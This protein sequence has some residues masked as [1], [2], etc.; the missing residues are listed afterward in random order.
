M[1]AGIQPG[2]AAAHNLQPQVTALEIRA[3]HVGDFVF[4]AGRWLQR[5][6]D[7]QHVVVVEV[8]P[9]YRVVGLRHRGLLFKT[10]HTTVRVYLGHPVAL[11]VLHV[12]AEHGGT[13]RRLRRLRQH[14]GEPV[15]VEDIVPQHQGHR[16]GAHELPSNHKRLREAVGHRL[17]GVLQRQPPC[18]PVTK[19]IAKA[20]QILRCGDDENVANTGQHQHRQRVV[21]H[22]LV[23]HREQLLAH[24]A[25]DRM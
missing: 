22:R 10:Q 4:A 19:Q 1:R 13:T 2:H 24:R 7:I 17:L 20:R 16:V 14:A 11:G 6:G 25:R 21:H 3:I 5:G 12:V 9:R 15:A 8:Q 18:A 23:V